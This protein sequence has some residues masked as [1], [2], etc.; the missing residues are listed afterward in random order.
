M[1]KSYHK[2]ITSAR[3]SKY[4]KAAQS[5]SDLVFAYALHHVLKP[6]ISTCCVVEFSTSTIKHAAV[7]VITDTKDIYLDSLGVFDWKLFKRRFNVPADQLISI[8]SVTDSMPDFN[9]TELERF[10]FYVRYLDFAIV[11][12][13]LSGDLD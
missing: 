13:E 3:L 4:R 10:N 11:G 1:K 5:N 2:F 7:H 6:Y 12:T 8:L 9:T